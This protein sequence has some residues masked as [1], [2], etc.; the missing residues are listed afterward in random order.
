VDDR[1]NNSTTEKNAREKVEVWRKITTMGTIYESI[2]LCKVM[3]EYSPSI[4][5]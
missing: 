3:I 1:E 5:G 4:G 2:F